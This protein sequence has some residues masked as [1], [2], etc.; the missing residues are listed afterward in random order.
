MPIERYGVL[1]ARPI[2][3][4]PGRG[5]TP[6][7]QIHAVDRGEDY[8]V[9]INVR[10]KPWPSELL[11]F[12]DDR[13]E[14]PLLD[15]LRNL[16]MGFS[17]QH[18]GHGSLA[19]DY[20]RGNLF[21]RRHMR[22]L[23]HDVPGPDNDLNELIDLWVG[24]ALRDE[25]ALLFA[26]GER[27]GP[28]AE[29]DPH[30]GFRPATG[31]HRVHM[32]QGSASAYAESDGPWQDGALLLYFPP[33][34]GGG[35]VLVRERWVAVFLAFQS[36]AWHTDDRSGRAVEQWRPRQGE[37]EEAAAAEPR[38]GVGPLRIVAAAVE[39]SAQ[40]TLLNAGSETV[41]LEGWALM[42]MARRLE[43]LSGALEPGQSLRVRLSG[44]G[45]RLAASGGLIT[46]V[47]PAGFKADG[48]SYSA[49]QARRLGGRLVF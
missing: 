32:N 37:A 11:Y 48:V 31:I 23:P 2:A 36:Q 22:A 29:P 9:A 25:D 41:T 16:S 33:V 8:R 38:G 45:A 7:Y 35:R 28:D 40:V 21:E 27:F 42:D 19:V 44:Q 12:V 3:G 5:R 10:S 24:R 4:R 17:G 26:F 14:H 39:P 47:E 15:G 34:R 30:F 20:V 6:H 46:L 18:Q 1:K 13:F 43:P 49:A